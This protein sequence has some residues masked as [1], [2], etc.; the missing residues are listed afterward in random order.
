[1]SCS[2]TQHSDSLDGVKSLELAI[3]WSLGLLA[4]LSL[5]LMC[6]LIVYL[7]NYNICQHFQTSQKPL[8]QTNTNFMWRLWVGNLFNWFWSFSLSY[9]T[10]V[11]LKIRSRS[12][13]S[14]HL[15]RSFH[16]VSASLVTI[17]P[18]V[19]KIACRQGLVDSCMTL[20]TFKI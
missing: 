15:L 16:D 13:K 8:G 1:M 5:R 3:L 9:M 18:L 19:Q 12:P 14:I 2:R 4:L 11:I 10:L 7:N 6:E 20:V 17:S